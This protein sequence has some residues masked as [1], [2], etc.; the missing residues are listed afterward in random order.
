MRHKGII[1]R[2]YE[3]F[4]AFDEGYDKGVTQGHR[5]TASALLNLGTLSDEQIASATQLTLDDIAA[6]RKT[7]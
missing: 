1:E 2:M 7:L 4:D 5:E 3:A 6:L